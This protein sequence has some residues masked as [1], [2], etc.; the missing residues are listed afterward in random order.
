SKT[1]IVL[2]RIAACQITQRLKMWIPE[3][4][5]ME[6]EQA[7]TLVRDGSRI[8]TSMTPSEPVGFFSK[9]HEYAKKV[10]DIEV[11]C[12]NPSRAYPC[13]VNDRDWRSLRLLVMFLT[14]QVRDQGLDH[15]QYVPQHLS[16]WVKN[17]LVEKPVDIFW[18]TCSVPDN[19]GFVSLGLNCC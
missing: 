4:R 16:Q 7:F 1:H 12:A 17:T 9:L 14:S 13:F 3:T 8:V 5:R 10:S 2:F 18:G 19:R 15:V 6:F 11:V